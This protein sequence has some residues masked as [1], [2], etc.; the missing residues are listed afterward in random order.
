L[1]RNQIRA[2][3]LAAGLVGWSFTAGID[4]PWRRHP[5]VQAALGTVLA[6]AAGAPLGL[7]QPAARSG[8]RL[9]TAVAGAVGAGVAVTT[10]VP[11]VRTAMV[12]RDLP[13][14]PVHWLGVEIPLGTVWSEET[15]FRG[16]LSTVAAAAFGSHAGRLL[17]AATFGLTHVPDAL[18]TGEPVAGTVLVTG[19]AGWVFALLG[20]RS[21][22]LLAPMLAH[23]AVNEAGAVAALAV[24]RFAKHADG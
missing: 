5:L 13:E 24:Q 12:D 21:G 1:N 9:G 23:L 7:R 17:Q 11:R 10:A 3:G 6:L 14:R 8:L 15:A 19:L 4:R 16:A 18:E 2:L 22:S 20:E